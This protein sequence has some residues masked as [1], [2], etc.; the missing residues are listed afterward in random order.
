MRPLRNII[1]EEI[2]AIKEAT[3]DIG[4]ARKGNGTT[5]YDKNQEERSDYKNIAHISDNGTITYYDKKL[6]SKIKKMIEK[7]ANKM[8]EIENEEI[9]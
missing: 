3:Y 6:P 8:K 9:K 7:E 4:M 2:K 1:R 5:V